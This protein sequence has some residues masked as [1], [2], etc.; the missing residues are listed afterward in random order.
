MLYEGA[1]FGL[2][3][4]YPANKKAYHTQ[5]DSNGSGSD[6]HGCT[7]EHRCLNERFQTGCRTALYLLEV[8]FTE[9]IDQ[10][11]FKENVD[12]TRIDKTDIEAYHDGINLSAVFIQ[13]LALASLLSRE[14]CTRHYQLLHTS[15]VITDSHGAI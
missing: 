11:I 13:A 6:Q 2:A 3:L 9:L 4:A 12:L 15:V 7:N 8:T 10:P 1:L 14:S 5:R